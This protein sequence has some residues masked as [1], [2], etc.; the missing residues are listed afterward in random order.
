VEGQSYA[1]FTCFSWLLAQENGDEFDVGIL[2]TLLDD[3]SGL[4]LHMIQQS[5]ASACRDICKDKMP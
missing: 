2:S 3:A 1:E 5:E 4:A